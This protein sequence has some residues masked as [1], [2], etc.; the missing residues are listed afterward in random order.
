MEIGVYGICV[1]CHVELVC[2]EYVLNIMEIGVHGIC[3]VCRVE[4]VCMEYV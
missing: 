3:V 2:M 1:V 4:L